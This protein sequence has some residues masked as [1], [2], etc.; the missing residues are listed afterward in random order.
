MF[1]WNQYFLFDLFSL[2]LLYLCYLD[3][4]IYWKLCFVLQY[5]ILILYQ[6]QW[7]CRIWKRRRQCKAAL[8]IPDD[9]N[10]SE[11][12]TSFHSQCCPLSDFQ[13]FHQLR[14]VSDPIL[15]SSLVNVLLNVSDR[16]FSS[17]N[18]V[19][20]FIDPVPYLL[21]WNPLTS[22]NEWSSYWSVM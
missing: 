11:I 1:L 8:M 19:A 15:H 18:L 7:P 6:R 21:L 20:S 10:N 5:C 4:L 3:F 2:E 22:T 9:G 16:K 14:R 17:V 12:H 13:Y